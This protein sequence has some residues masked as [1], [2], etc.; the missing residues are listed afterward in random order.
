M[1]G[2]F[3]QCGQQL[4]LF[5]R[6]RALLFVSGQHQCAHVQSK[7]PAAGAAGDRHRSG[8]AGQCAYPGQ[9]LAYV[10]RLYQI[11]V[12][13]RVQTVHSVAHKAQRRR[14]QHRRVQALGPR[15]AQHRKPIPSGQHP[16]QNAQPEHPLAHVVQRIV[17]VSAYV[18]TV[19]LL[20]QQRRHGRA[21][22]FVVFHK[23]YPHV[24]VPPV[25]Q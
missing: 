19:A 4:R 2:V 15:C 10:E 16:V 7:I 6:E 17:A 5:F 21:Q 8:A 11:I 1:S 25:P 18:H 24:F 20:L 13:A 14:H 3:H 23:Q 22:G 9:Q 12:C